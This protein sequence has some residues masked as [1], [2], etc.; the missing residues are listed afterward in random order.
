VSGRH[1][2][3]RWWGQPG[4]RGG[5]RG[6]RS[7]RPAWRFGAALFDHLKQEGTVPRFEELAVNSGVDTIKPGDEWVIIPQDGA[8]R[9]FVRDGVGYAPGLKSE[10]G[11]VTLKNVPD[12]KSKD[13]ITTPA[14]RGKNDL[15]LKLTAQKNGLGSVVLTKGTEWHRI[16]FSVH[17]KKTLKVSFF[18]LEDPVNGGR[19]TRRSRF[20]ESDA[21]G[22]VADLN[23]VFGPQANIWFDPGKAEGL[24]LAGLPQ[25]VSDDDA[26]LLATKKDGAPINIFLAGTTI[27]S[28]EKDFP[29][30]FY[31]IKE[32]LIVV[33][34]QDPTSTNSKPMLKTI[35]HEIAH[36][37][38]YDKKASTPGHDY[39]KTCLYQSDVLGT[40]DGA[41][42]K[43]PHQRVLDWNP[44]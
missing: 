13:N 43:I 30:G 35:A 15:L 34:D 5:G 29:N 6:S 4:G 44:W 14:T 1:G 25:V 16:N 20:K 21:A 12:D 26:P 22:W 37:L 23:G 27:R 32:K 38:N 33:K 9:V 19:A 17:P 41:D 28:N 24:P 7:S 31:A 18:F 8:N 11:R 40:R 39:Y 42:I 2:L 36:L 10:G 3:T